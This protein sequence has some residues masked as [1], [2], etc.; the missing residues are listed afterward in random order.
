M[1]AQ[2]GRGKGGEGR[3]RGEGKGQGGE[4]QRGTGHQDIRACDVTLETKQ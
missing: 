1:C 3:E 4:R 2:E